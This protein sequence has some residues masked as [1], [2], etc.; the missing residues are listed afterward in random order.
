MALHPARREHDFQRRIAAL[1]HMQHVADRSAGRRGD[2][3]DPPRIKRQ[4][5]LPFRGEQSFCIQLLLE[6]LER[7]LQRAHSLQFHRRDPQLVLPTR[8]I[9]RHFAVQNHFS[10][11]LQETTVFRRLATEQHAAQLR[12]SV[13]EREIRVPG[14]LKRK[15]VTSPGDP[16]LADLFFGQSF[17]L[18]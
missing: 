17:H 9:H 10:A 7:R 3:A 18:P 1:D 4:R 12:F 8:L 13:L 6:L 15:L 11:I 5:A 2:D 16:N 14:T